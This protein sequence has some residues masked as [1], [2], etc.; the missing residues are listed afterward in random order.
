MYFTLRRHRGYLTGALQLSL[1]QVSHTV[2][3]YVV[4]A[5]QTLQDLIEVSEAYGTQVLKYL[6]L[7]FRG[8]SF[9][10]KLKR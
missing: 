1:D 4:L 2:H 7:F 9:I 8:R 5:G 3:A 10:N 6:S